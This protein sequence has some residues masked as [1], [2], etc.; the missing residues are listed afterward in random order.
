MTPS[1]RLLEDGIGTDVELVSRNL[2][3]GKHDVLLDWISVFV[4]AFLR[5][6]TL[7]T[8]RNASLINANLFS[9]QSL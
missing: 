5:G 2:L 1:T 7:E 8:H 4:V 6:S 3:S 9:N